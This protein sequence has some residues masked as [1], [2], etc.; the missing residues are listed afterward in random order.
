VGLVF[1]FTRNDGQRHLEILV[2]DRNFILYK[3]QYIAFS[4]PFLND[5]QI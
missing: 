4:Q 2:V 1:F 3:L 5:V